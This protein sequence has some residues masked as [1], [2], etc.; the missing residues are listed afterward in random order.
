MTFKQ[1]CKRYKVTAKERRQLILYLAA[2][3]LAA[4]IQES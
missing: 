3:R 4:L 2:L 1:F